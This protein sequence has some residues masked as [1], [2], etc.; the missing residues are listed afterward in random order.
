MRSIASLS[1]ACGSWS[2][3]FS[4][5]GSSVGAR[6]ARSC[7]LLNMAAITAIAARID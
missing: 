1:I 7:A 6:I 4:P 5:I 2:R 3:S